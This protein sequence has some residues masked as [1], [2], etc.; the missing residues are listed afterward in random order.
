[1]TIYRPDRVTKTLTTLVSIAYFGVMA[2]AAL[3][4]SAALVVRLF[5][6]DDP[7]W[8]WGLRVPAVTGT[9]TTVVT[10]WGPAELEMKRVRGTLRL[11]IGMLPWRF[12]AVLWLHAAAAFAL[13]LLGLYHLRRLFQRVRDGAPFDAENAQR[14]RWLGMALLGLALLNGVAELV[15]SL[16]VRRGLSATNV[17]IPVSAPIDM[18]LVFVAFVLLALAR[19][20]RHGT[21][22]EDDQSLVV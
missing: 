10:S 1:M 14:L 22:L 15:T 13:M 3:V 2:G 11:P 16:F 4:L 12:V 8:T 21:D 18:P 6:G 9:P 5:A 17:T 19:I 20:F 7:N